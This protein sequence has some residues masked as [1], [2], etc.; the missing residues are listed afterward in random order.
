MVGGLLASQMLV[1]HTRPV[2]YLYVHRLGTWLRSR[3]ARRALQ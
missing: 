1:L 2:V 3:F